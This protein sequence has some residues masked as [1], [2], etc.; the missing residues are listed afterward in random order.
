MSDLSPYEASKEGYD[1]LR[2]LGLSES[3]KHIEQLCD[4]E[5]YYSLHINEEEEQLYK[6]YVNLRLYFEFFI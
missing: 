3:E 4:E 1:A 2:W 5:R 6:G